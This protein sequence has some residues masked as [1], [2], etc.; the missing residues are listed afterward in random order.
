MKERVVSFTR[1]GLGLNLHN[2]ISLYLH[3]RDWC[4]YTVTVGLAW[5]V[6]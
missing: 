4:H 2:Y 3:R 6:C 1:K 5:R